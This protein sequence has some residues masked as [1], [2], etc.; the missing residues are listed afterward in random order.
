MEFMDLHIREEDLKREIEEVFLKALQTAR[1]VGGPFVEEFEREFARWVGVR[2]AVSVGSGTQAVKY[3]LWALGIGPGDEVITTP[4]TFV[5]TAEAIASLG[6]KPV[7]VDINPETLQID[8]GKIEGAITPRTKAILPVHLFGAPAEMDTIMEIAKRHGLRVVE[9]AA[10]A[11]GAIYRGRKAG[12]LGD[13]GAFSFYPTKNLSAM[14]EAGAVTTDSEKIA[15]MVE[16]IKNHGQDRPYHSLF[17]GENG[18]MDALQAGILLKKLK[19]IDR[20]NSRRMEIAE[21]YRRELSGIVNMQ[22]VLEGTV[23]VYHLFVI[24]HPERDKIKER[25]ASSGIPSK[26]YYPIPLHLQKAFSGLG[27]KKGDFPAAERASSQMLAL[28]IGP[29]MSQE[30]AYRVVESLKRALKK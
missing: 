20:W 30:D 10:Q 4:L 21:I 26:T 13:C 8:E 15:N 16:L 1:Y 27:Y 19:Y 5:A 24:L 29:W 11:H 9:D 22:K 3:C 25:L 28:P 7:F 17:V 6:A 12:S 2:R 14:G 18:R 23:S